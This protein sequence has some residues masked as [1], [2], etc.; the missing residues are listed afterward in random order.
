M[1]ARGSYLSPGCPH[2]GLRPPTGERRRPPTSNPDTVQYTH[3]ER[4]RRAELEAAR[5]R[6]QKAA[7]ELRDLEAAQRIER[8]ERDA[9][10]ARRGLR[11]SFWTG[12][13]VTVRASQ[14]ARAHSREL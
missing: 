5:A 12:R 6:R 8:A 9:D 3:D 10:L 11:R 13:I 4:V 7:S 2:S 14:R 1:G